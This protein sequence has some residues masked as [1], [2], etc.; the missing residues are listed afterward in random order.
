MMAT[1][2]QHTGM[3]TTGASPKRI[4][5]DVDAWQGLPEELLHKVLAA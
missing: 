2:T 4:G 1:L 3:T 5:T